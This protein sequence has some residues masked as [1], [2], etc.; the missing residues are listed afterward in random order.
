MSQNVKA[1]KWQLMQSK[2]YE[3][4]GQWRPYLELLGATEGGGRNL[5]GG[6]W[7]RDCCDMKRA[8]LVTV[9]DIMSCQ[10]RD[11]HTSM[12]LLCTDHGLEV[13]GNPGGRGRG[14]QADINTR[15]A[16][17]HD[18]STLVLNWTI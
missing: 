18:A 14:H 4:F 10:W 1:L 6:P 5:T 11:M 17:V 13:H 2:L 8:Q 16:D 9:N 15:R 12:T 3:N 7:N